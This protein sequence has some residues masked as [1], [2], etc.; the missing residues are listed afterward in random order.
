MRNSPA[1]K[2]RPRPATDRHGNVI[3]TRSVK[4]RALDIGAS[5]ARAEEISHTIHT[6][7]RKQ[8]GRRK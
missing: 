2:P 4:Q 7:L 3:Q 1:S 6:R 8:M 5:P